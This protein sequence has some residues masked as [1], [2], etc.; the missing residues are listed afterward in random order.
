MRKQNLWD[1]LSEKY[2]PLDISEKVKFCNIFK[3]I[4]ELSQK[5][6]EDATKSVEVFFSE[7]NMPANNPYGL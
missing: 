4:F 2:N 6:Y 7:V 3:A 5:L 1:Y